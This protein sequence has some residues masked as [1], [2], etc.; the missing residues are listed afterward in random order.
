[1]DEARDWLASVRFDDDEWEWYMKNRSNLNSKAKARLNLAYG[2]ADDILTKL[3]RFGY[4]KVPEL[5]LIGDEEIHDIEFNVV[6]SNTSDVNVITET[7]K[8]IA[9]A[10]LDSIKKQLS[11]KPV[12]TG[13]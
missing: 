9:Q 6:I 12:E 10:Q 5:K 11:F 1:M 4:R 2:F 8:K 3:H 7:Y 13:K